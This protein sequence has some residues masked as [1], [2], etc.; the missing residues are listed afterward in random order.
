M[1][2]SRTR[3][4]HGFAAPLA[5]SC[6][7]L[8]GVL[9]STAAV[10]L[11]CVGG[12]PGD[13]WFS[14]RPVQILGFPGCF[15]VNGSVT[16]PT[17]SPT[18]LSGTMP[19]ACDYQASQNRAICWNP[20]VG[21][22]GTYTLERT[23][24][25]SNGSVLQS[26]DTVVVVPAIRAYLELVQ[27]VA[28]IGNVN[29]FTAGTSE[30][31]NFSLDPDKRTFLRVH[32]KYLDGTTAT[33][34]DVQMRLRAFD[35]D[36]PLDGSG[37]LTELPGSPRMTLEP[38]DSIAILEVDKL[39][40]NWVPSNTFELDPAWITGASNNIDL[41]I[42]GSAGEPL[43]ACSDQASRPGRCSLQGIRVLPR[44]F[45]PDG[46]RDDLL[47]IHFLGIPWRTTGG[48]LHD[49][50]PGNGDALMKDIA[51]RI[52]S[53]FPASKVQWT[54]RR[55]K[56]TLELPS[57]PTAAQV[58]QLIL[59]ALNRAARVFG[60][61]YGRENHDPLLK[62]MSLVHAVLV[63]PPAVAASANLGVGAVG[64]GFS[65]SFEVPGIPQAHLHEIGHAL[66]LFHAVNSIFDSSQGSDV[67]HL[68]GACGAQAPRSEVDDTAAEYPFFF[69]VPGSQ[70]PLPTLGIHLPGQPFQDHVFGFDLYN[71]G[72]PAPGIRSD[73]G[74]FD[75]M[76]YCHPIWPSVFTLNR[77][78]ILRDEWDAE[79]PALGGTSRTLRIHNGTTDGQSVDFD[80]VVE[81]ETDLEITQSATGQFTLTL[82]DA[83]GGIILQVLFDPTEVEQE[84]PGAPPLGVFTV[85]VD[86]NPAMVRAEISFQGTVIGAQQASI[87]GPVVQVLSPNGGEMLPADVVTFSWNASDADGDPLTYGV[88]YSADNGATWEM[89][90]ATLDAT[91]LDVDMRTLTGSDMARWR[92]SAS[93]GFLV[94]SDESDGFFTVDN[95]PP[96]VAIVAPTDG[97]IFSGAQTVVLSARAHDRAE[98]VLSGPSIL[99]SSSLDGPLGSGETVH[100]PAQ[101]L[102]EGTHLITV[103]AADSKGATAQDSISVTTSLAPLPG[104]A[105]LTL[106]ASVDRP[107][108]LV[109]QQV[110]LQIVTRNTGSGTA[111]EV[112][113]TVAVPAELIFSSAT[114]SAGSCT[115][116]GPTVDCAHGVLPLGGEAIAD[117]IFD[118][119]A[120]GTAVLSMATTSTTTDRE[121][122]TNQTAISLTV[123]PAL[124]EDA[125]GDGFSVAQGDCDDFDPLRSPAVFEQCNGIDDNCDFMIDELG[126]DL[127]LDS[128][129][130]TQ[131]TC[132]GADGCSVLIAADGDLDGFLG[133]GCGGSDCD[134]TDAS[135]WLSPQTVDDV[136]VSGTDPTNLSWIGQGLSAGPATQYSI[137][138]GS[139]VS[140]TVPDGA[141]RTCIGTSNTPMFGDLE[142][143]PPAGTAF[144]YLIQAVNP[145]GNGS[146]G[147]FDRDLE[148]PVCP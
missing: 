88:E 40:Q 129:I 139:L 10:A 92:V 11:G 60:A 66:G 96:D 91:T 77:L 82:L 128:L 104:L 126:D 23:Y 122:G 19:F 135:V 110:T 100:L 64:G 78:R 31:I 109:G 45:L 113:T 85:P 102:S 141:L 13:S 101:N 18:P 50:M 26:S 80:P 28:G 144:W 124:S 69:P 53:A 119:V 117:L 131:S 86:A 58:D 14:G 147:S 90:A 98:G 84:D 16:Q 114:S 93:D 121:P 12:G 4:R 111:L 146:L 39:R 5:L 70:R 8:V 37:C 48:A 71:G 62:P 29:V 76:S 136:Q 33:F 1:F 99:W 22:E 103:T 125:D 17:I 140:G 118:A 20:Q 74:Y 27:S 52:Q 61:K 55:L 87:N 148:I 89:V 145:C 137:M 127:C 142:P 108:P 83:G 132:L 46:K 25:C 65:A 75:L 72:Q 56:R 3:R 54:A 15:E 51:M 97:T 41:W 49:P 34:L 130:C 6:I 116:A 36:L 68:A 133:A 9:S 105:N 42:E 30:P 7:L 2:T 38:P 67:D 120:E 79:L 115:S 59:K 35:E 32:L 81:V 106:A 138:R 47:K 24:N 21:D 112:T 107:A 123:R 44:R 95:A 57:N 43:F 94:A 134:D 143:G 73:A 63:D